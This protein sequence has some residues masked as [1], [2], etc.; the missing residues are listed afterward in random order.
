MML[1]GKTAIVTGGTG[2]L[3]AAIVRAFLAEGARV[4]VPFRKEGELERLRAGL[5]AEQAESAL[6]HAA[7]PHG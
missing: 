5:D 4:A 1:E 7:R 3:G 6:G 2:A